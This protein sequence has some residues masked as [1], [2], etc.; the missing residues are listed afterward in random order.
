MECAS[1]AVCG[2]FYRDESAWV[3]LLPAGTCD[4]ILCSSTAIARVCLVEI[5]DGC[6]CAKHAAPW[7]LFIWASCHRA[8]CD[9]SKM[10]R[11][12]F[13]VIQAMKYAK[14]SVGVEGKLA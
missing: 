3:F 1:R 4:S 14:G 9:H 11:A 2:A 8:K 12:T 6:S 7:M 10:T 13:F 5:G